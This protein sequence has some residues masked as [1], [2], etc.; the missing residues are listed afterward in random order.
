[1]DTKFHPYLRI[2]LVKNM[3]KPNLNNLFNTF[4]DE[5]RY[6]ARKA[7]ET[8]RGYQSSFGLL[9]SLIPAIELETVSA[10]SLTLFFKKLSDRE[11]ISGK[12]LKKG[13]KT[14]TSATYRSK[15][16]SFFAWLKTKGYLAENPF[17]G[18]PCPQPN[19]DDLKWLRKEE[20][21]NLISSIALN[22]HNRFL[23][24]RN[25]LIIL[26]GLYCGLRKNEILSLKTY[27]LDLERR[28]LTVQA[29]TS[30]SRRERSLPMH[31]ELLKG[32]KFYLEER[33]KLGYKTPYLLVS[34]NRDNKLSKGGFKHFIEKLKAD[35]G[36]KFHIHQLRHT[37]AVNMLANGCDLAK[38]KQLLGHTDIRMT[39]K[40]LR[41]LPPELMR[42]DIAKLSLAGLV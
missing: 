1:M 34:D 18:I 14:S 33:K 10:E 4:L 26:I 24:E 40:Y 13:V 6:V 41:C 15:L 5:Q 27:D 17:T 9:K 7:E 25:K 36:S 42:S 3:Q 19:Y 28:I 39:V 16:N 37:F 30:K 12:L 31:D 32:L 35:S 21:Q 11:R 29:I 22:S 8:L 2:P 20:I 23:A 38:L